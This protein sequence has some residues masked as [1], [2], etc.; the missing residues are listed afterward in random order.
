MEHAGETTEA[1]MEERP[2]AGSL[3][4]EDRTAPGDVRLRSLAELY[5]E[6]GFFE[7]R[8]ATIGWDEFRSFTWASGTVLTDLNPIRRQVVPLG[9]DRRWL[10]P[11]LPTT[12]VDATTT[13]VQYLRQSARTLAGTATIRPL[14]SVSAKP[15]TSSTVEFK[16][17]QLEQVATIS[18][19]IPRIHA[20]QPMFQSVIEQDLRL[21]IGDG[22]DEVVRRGVALAGTIVKGTDDILEVTRKAMTLVEAEGYA[23]DT[24]A[25][26]PAGAQAL[27]LLRAPGTEK[28]YIFTPGQFAG[29]LWA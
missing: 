3:R 4:V 19:D 18:K 22:L 12:Q 6:R 10:Y 11:V 5:A 21:S 8:V 23:P 15:E 26:D 1:R 28:M 25:I 16:S 29:G 20:M 27:D 2:P 9:Y 17:Q 7:N 24:L 13:A 14:D